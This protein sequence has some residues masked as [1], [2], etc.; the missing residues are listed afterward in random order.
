MILGARDFCY[1]LVRVYICSLL[2]DQARHSKSVMDLAVLNQWITYHP[3]CLIRDNMMNPQQ[4]KHAEIIA[5]DV[6]LTPGVAY[7]GMGDV[8]P[9]GN[10]RA[11][12]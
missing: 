6:D 10:L 11:K 9:T 8:D 7:R 1:T 2:L 12:Y 3:L 4:A 5:L